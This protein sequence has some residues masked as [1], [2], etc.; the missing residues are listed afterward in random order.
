MLQIKRKIQSSYLNEQAREK[1]A[2]NEGKLEIP[3]E[4]S[5]KERWRC[6]GVAMESEKSN[7]GSQL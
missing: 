2:M 7:S 4:V 3:S 1:Q 5:A 6:G